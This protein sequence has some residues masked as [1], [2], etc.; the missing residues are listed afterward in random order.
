MKSDK[1]NI[2]EK[3]NF[4]KFISRLISFMVVSVLFRIEWHNRENV[5]EE[6]ATL[7]FANHMS[8]FDMFIIAA[9]IKRWVYWMA[10]Q[11][12]FKNPILGAWLNG[13][14]AFPV[15]RNTT[16]V[17]SVRSLFK[18]LDEGKIVGVFPEGTRQK[19]SNKLKTIKPGA[20]LFALKSQA[21]IIPVKVEGSYKLFRKID[22]YF[23]KPFKIKGE[24]D[25]HYT[26]KELMEISRDIMKNIYSLKGEN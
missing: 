11:E 7:L 2:K 16:D 1:K 12:L 15:K 21:S 5:P 20:A 6:G 22:V 3:I 25:K 17:K 24:L 19:N 23:G 8:E 4:I 13:V 14:G 10:K 18:L 26:R 9:R